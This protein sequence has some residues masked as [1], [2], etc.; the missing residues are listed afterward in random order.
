MGHRITLFLENSD[1]ILGAAKC[2][3]FEFIFNHE[4][5]WFNKP[6]ETVNSG[7]Y[8]YL[9]LRKSLSLSLSVLMYEPN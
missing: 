4:I 2:D 8:M 3:D 5:K 6:L 9:F 1:V 7:S